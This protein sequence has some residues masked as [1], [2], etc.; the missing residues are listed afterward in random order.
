MDFIT[1]DPIKLYKKYLIPSMGSAL[2][3]S[4]YS[5]V[6]TI[7][8]G[9][10]EGELGAA[11]M[12]VIC[13]LFGFMVFLSILCGIG[14]SVLLS[15]ARGEGKPE[16][17]NAFFTIALGMIIVLTLIFWGL[18]LLFHDPI[19]MFLGADEVILAKVMEYAK[20]IIWTFPVF[21]APTFIG[22]FLRNDGAPMLDMAAVIIGG[23]VNMFGDW[24]FVFPLGMRME[25]AAI[26]TVLGTSLQVLI[27]CGHFF[28]KKCG[29]RLVK[30]GN[31]WRG[32]RKIC[33]IGVGA[34]ILDLGTVLIA[35]LMN[36]QIMRYGGP[37]ELAVYGVVSAISPLFQ[38]FFGGVGQTIQPLVSANCGAGETERTRLFW[39]FGLITSLMIGVLTSCLGEFF[40]VP[41]ARLFMDASPEAIA[42]VPSVFQPYFLL[43]VPLGVTVLATYYLQAILHGKISM[44]IALLRSALVSG[45]LICLLPLRWGLAGVWLALPVSE[46]LVMLIALFYIRKRRLG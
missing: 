42:I 1:A 41:I 20:W 23:C 14:G 21:I 28:R 32:V 26:A 16:K 5:F 34:G 40:P 22:S 18:L 39:R 33:L 35:V 12:A 6:D 9:Q 10:S 17:A 15:A 30:P 2:A 3:V 25:G 37:V 13:P 45:L 8:V 46:L 43:F 7:A 36:N 19:F 11:A 31:W 4:I 44:L 29:L 24:F 27:M 38:A